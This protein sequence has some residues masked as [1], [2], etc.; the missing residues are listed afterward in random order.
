M[1]IQRRLMSILLGLAAGLMPL[2]RLEAAP[3]RG[4][5]LTNID[6]A[7]LYDP[8]NLTQALERLEELGVN[9][10]Y[11]TVWNGGYTLYPSP[12][13]KTWLGK[14]QLPELEGRDFLAELIPQAKARNQRVIAWFEL[15]LMTPAEAPWLKN[16]RDWLTQTATGETI[17]LEGKTLPR[18][19]LNPLHPEVQRLMTEILVDLAT[20][21]DLDGIQLDDH[22]GYPA[23]M[24]YDPLTVAQFQADHGGENPP[25]PPALDPQQDCVSQN[26]SW[27]A[28]VDWRADRLTEFTETLVKTLRRSKPGLI[29]SVSPNPQTFSKNC[30]LLD[31]QA[32]QKRGLIDELALQVYR[33]DFGA[34][35]REL[36]KPEV[37]RVKEEIPVLVG[38]L[39]GLKGAPMP[40]AD[41]EAQ[42]RW[43]QNQGFSGV[44]FFFYESLWN[45]GPESPAL[46]QKALRELLNQRRHAPKN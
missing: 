29:I 38:V 6:S 19:W 23:E 40:L 43:A 1:V 34:F 13:G 32:W 9:T 45:F 17:W 8:Q 25:L 35:Q 42:V 36:L 5:W 33:R 7:V 14:P 24:G 18:V 22:F 46:R 30:F 4:V 3:L 10:L 28:W 44:S 20:R 21:Y 12:T 2:N 41:L 11:P 39:A 31:W 37:Q 16:R 27:Q 15:G 26:R